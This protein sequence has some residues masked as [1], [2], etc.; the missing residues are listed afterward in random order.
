MQNMVQLREGREGGPVGD[1]GE[2]VTQIQKPALPF[3]LLGDSKPVGLSQP[4]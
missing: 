4:N 1:H 3:K 2:S